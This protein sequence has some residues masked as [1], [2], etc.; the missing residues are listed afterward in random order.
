MQDASHIDS[1][2]T[3]SGVHFPPPFIYVGGFLAGLLLK[4]LLPLPALPRS[5]SLGLAIVLLIPGFGLLYWS[6]AL[7]FRRKT[8]PLPFRPTTTLV[9]TGPYRWTR[10]PMYLGMLL[11]YLGLAFWF[12]V[13]WAVVLAPAVAALVGRLVIRK[14]E[15]YL[16]AR[17][18]EAYR[19]YKADVGRWLGKV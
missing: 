13:L 10:N 15:Q 12:G 19:Q 8:S 2:D 6:L 17:F 7:F 14:E 16:E 11:A 1:K 5:V 9:I 18:G 4:R 3:T